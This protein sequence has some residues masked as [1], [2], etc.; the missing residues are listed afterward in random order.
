MLIDIKK[1]GV[2]DD[3]E[4]SR[5]SLS[6]I[7]ED[8]SMQPILQDQS[9]A[10]DELRNYLDTLSTKFDAVVTDHHLRR[11]SSYFPIDGAQLVAECYNKAIPSLLVTRYEQAE[12]QEIRKFREK[13]PVV[14]TP[15][16]Y[17]VTALV[18]GFE[19][20]INEFNGQI[21]SERKSW[22]TLVRIDDITDGRNVF[23][24]IPAWNSQE[25]VAINMDS[26]PPDLQLKVKPDMRLFAK[27]NIGSEDP[28]E[29]FLTGWEY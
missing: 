9:V 2:I 24:I 23:V 25:A 12:I 4:D 14:L 20:C 18:A 15:D 22:R 28:N 5:N 21:T 19:K 1:V 8:A 3:Y 10:E 26:L 27:V 16:E 11:V 6:W 7:V 13:I 17:D 29:L